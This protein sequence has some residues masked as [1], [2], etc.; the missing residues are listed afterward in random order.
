MKLLLDTHTFIWWDSSP[1]ALSPKVRALCQDP[2]N[3]LIRSAVSAWEMQIKAQLGK[4]TRREG[5]ARSGEGEPRISKTNR[6]HRRS[7]GADRRVGSCELAHSRLS[8][9]A[10]QIVPPRRRMNMSAPPAYRIDVQDRE[11]VIRLR[12][13][14]LSQEEVSRFLDYLELESIRRRSALSE[15][16]AAGLA[17]AIDRGVWAR[18]RSHVEGS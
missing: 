8:S 15:D 3:T 9:G 16:E 5:R 6:G 7:A 11:L 2:G 14:L 13:D 17:A 1:T 18:T 4:L 10:K 12:Q